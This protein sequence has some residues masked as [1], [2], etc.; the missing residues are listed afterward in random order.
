MNKINL[1]EFES[2]E[3][4]FRFKEKLRKKPNMNLKQKR[5]AHFNSS[6][7]WQNHLRE[8][9]FLVRFFLILKEKFS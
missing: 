2:L 4:E 5:E 7:I 8:A 6:E 3:H 9:P 1:E